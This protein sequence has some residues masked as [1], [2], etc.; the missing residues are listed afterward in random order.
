MS[1]VP[2]RGRKSLF[3]PLHPTARIFVMSAQRPEFM[4]LLSHSYKYAGQTL[5]GGCTIKSRAP[6]RQVETT[7]QSLI[8]VM[9]SG[10][11]TRCVQPLN[12]SCFHC[13]HHRRS[14]ALA[15]PCKISSIS[16]RG[17]R[18]INQMLVPLRP[19][20]EFHRSI[21]MYF[22]YTFTKGTSPDQ[23]NPNQQNATRALFFIYSLRYIKHLWGPFFSGSE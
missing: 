1:P 22:L 14:E 15:A 6:S 23:L 9:P 5:A 4:L 12:D 10:V 2:R 13:L 17:A 21:K 16:T 7:F 20:C 18:Y 11:L 3:L 8:T 19:T